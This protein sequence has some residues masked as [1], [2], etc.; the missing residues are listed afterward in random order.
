VQT[1]PDTNP[2]FLWQNYENGAIYATVDAAF[3]VWGAIYRRWM[4]TGGPTGWV[5]FPKSDVTATASLSGQR[6][7]F[8]VT[9]PPV[10]GVG[11]ALVE[12][13]TIFFSEN[14]GARVVKSDDAVFQKWEQLGLESG[15][16]GYPTSN[17]PGSFIAGTSD[18]PANGTFTVFEGGYISSGPDKQGVVTRE[19][20][21]SSLYNFYL[22]NCRI[23]ETRAPLSDTLKEF[24]SVTVDGVTTSSLLHTLDS[25]GATPPGELP[26]GLPDNLLQPIKIDNPDSVIIFVYSLINSGADT[27]N[28]ELLSALHSG[29]EALKGKVASTLTEDILG[30]A[31]TASLAGSIVGAAIAFALEEVIAYLFGGSDGPVVYGT[32]VWSGAGLNTYT[33]G[34]SH[35]S[36]PI[37]YKSIAGSGS[38]YFIQFQVDRKDFEILQV[39]KPILA[40]DPNF[41]A[42]K[43]RPARAAPKKV[44]PA[45]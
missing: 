38:D 14:S 27:T 34:G 39:R 42:A 8:G 11:N 5:G 32:Q 43:A 37:E 15:Q 25:Y 12:N 7:D 13:W 31:L 17:N 20:Y 6:C 21:S 1:S 10:A 40:I 9:T 19:H 18:R 4:E 29:V 45:K 44:A 26:I 35:M 22:A 36:P 23:V 30:K 3:V 28:G 16:L 2:P 41:A 24:L 33:A